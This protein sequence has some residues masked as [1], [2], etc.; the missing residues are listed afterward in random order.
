MDDDF[1]ILLS[2]ED[3][4]TR[5]GSGF[6]LASIEGILLGVYEYTPLGWSSY[7]PLPESISSISNKKG[8]I[9]SLNIDDCCFEWAILTWYVKGSHRCRVDKNYFNEEHQYDFSV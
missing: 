5:K 9:N 3:A 2:E 8:V 6:T 4:C 7:I 1:A